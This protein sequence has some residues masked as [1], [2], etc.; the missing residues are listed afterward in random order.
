MG[1]NT[2][3]AR[4]LSPA[5]QEDLRR[6]VVGA[7][8]KQGMR[9]GVAVR[10]FG[11]SRTAVYQWTRAY[12]QGGVVAL[13]SRPRGRPRRSRLAG[14]QA[15]LAVRLITDRCP[16]QLKMPFAL[17]TRPAVGQLLAERFGI[18][19]SLWTVGRYLKKWNLTPQKPL[20]RAYERDPKAVERWLREE[21]PTIRAQ[22]RRE[23]GA[24]HWGDQMGLRSDDQGGRS[25]GRRGQ[26]PVIPSTGRRFGCNMMSAI[27]NRGGLAFMIFRE[28]FTGKV[29]IRFL[30]RLM[31]HAKRKV[32]LILDRHP[33][34]RSAMVTHWLE[35][36]AARIRLFFLPGYSPELNPDE[37]LNQD[38]KSN[39]LKRE[40]PKDLPDMMRLARTYLRATQCRPGIVRNYFQ[41]E[42]VRYASA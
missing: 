29:M 12:G 8:V 4:H 36:H 37:Y 40:R 31:R 41:A 14:H 16:D 6:R 2:R 3:D 42:D 10:T 21:Y 9:P 26:T 15:A 23:H 7:V 39:A 5:A 28:R 32:F 25:Y 11:V 19:V 1:M 13:R 38:V 34:H 30:R 17:W 24:I 27:T 33:V 18:Q 22:A 35:A 20:R